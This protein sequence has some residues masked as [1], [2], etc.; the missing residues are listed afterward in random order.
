MADENVSKNSNVSSP[1]KRPDRQAGQKPDKAS[2]YQ[3]GEKIHGDKLEHDPGK[4][5]PGQRSTD[6]NRQNN[7]KN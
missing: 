1:G 2:P 3:G 7:Q 6:V 4:Q 5:N